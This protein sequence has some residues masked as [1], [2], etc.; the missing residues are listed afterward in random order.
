MATSEFLAK[1]SHDLRT[2]L[3]A[4]IG[5][6]DLTGGA[7]LQKRE[8]WHLEYSGYISDA[9]NSLLYLVNALLDLS[10]MEAGKLDLVETEANLVGLLESCIVDVVGT[11]LHE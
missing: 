2:P 5:F 7:S 9:G 11:R 6:A 1:M 10:Q 4:I 8:G 3:N